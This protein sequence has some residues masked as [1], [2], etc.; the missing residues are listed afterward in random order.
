MDTSIKII[1]CTASD[2]KVKLNENRS[3]FHTEYGL[4]RKDHVAC[5]SEWR[6]RE[7]HDASAL[8]CGEAFDPLLTCAILSLYR[9]GDYDRPTSRTAVPI[10]KQRFNNEAEPNICANAIANHR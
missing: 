3:R 5:Y 10:A 2:L 6:N 1:R 9:E 4:E 7:N 8:F